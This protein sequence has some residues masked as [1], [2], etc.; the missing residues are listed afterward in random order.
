M[1]RWIDGLGAARGSAEEL[2]PAP[3]LTRDK[4]VMPIGPLKARSDPPTSSATPK[5]VQFKAS[6]RKRLRSS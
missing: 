5:G 6:I 1:S 3:M 2:P 4:S